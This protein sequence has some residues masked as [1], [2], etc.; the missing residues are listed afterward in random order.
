MSQPS[1]FL[2]QVPRSLE[3]KFLMSSFVSLFITY[4]SDFYKDDSVFDVVLRGVGA[5]EVWKDG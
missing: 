5:P 1:F 4:F 2:F 3:S